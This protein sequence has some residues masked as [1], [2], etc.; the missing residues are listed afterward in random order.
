MLIRMI[1]RLF[2]SVLI[3]SLSLVSCGGIKN[4]TRNRIHQDADY[5]HQKA[6]RAWKQMSYVHS[7]EGETC[8]ANLHVQQY[9]QR[10]ITINQ[11]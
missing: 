6:E 7:C 5:F 9:S 10:F 2:I 3:I 8:V 1:S 11:S 4:S